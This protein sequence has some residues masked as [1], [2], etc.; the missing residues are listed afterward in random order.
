MNK[1]NFEEDENEFGETRRLD[2]INDEIKKYEHN[3]NLQ[4]KD[5]YLNH[6]QS[7]KFHTTAEN[8]STQGR[9]TENR[10]TSY[11]MRQPS[12]NREPVRKSVPNNRKKG[13][14][15]RGNKNNLLVL[16]I[17]GLLIF[18]CVFLSVF[19]SMGGNNSKKTVFEPDN[20]IQT[21]PKQPK[22][23]TI[24]SDADEKEEEEKEEQ[25]ER[26]ALI[27]E[28]NTSK[29]L[30]VYDITKEKND[31]IKTDKN[32]EVVDEKGDKISLSAIMPGDIVV[33][34]VEEET[35]I[36]TK[37]SFTK[38]TWEK[39]K[40]TKT[41]ID[42]DKKSIEIEGKSYQYTDETIF[43][44]KNKTIDPSRLDEIDV[45]CAKGINDTVWSVDVLEYHGYIVIKNKNKI[46]NGTIEINNKKPVSL[47]SLDKITISEGAHSIVIKGSNIETYTAD[48]FIV[49]DEEF[50]IDLSNTQAKTSVLIVKANVDNYQLY[51]NG[52]LTD[53]TEPVVLNQ[54]D[55]TV[56]VT[57][58]GYLPFEQKI[59]VTEPSVEVNAVLQEEVKKGS[60]SIVTNPTA[61]YIYVNNEYVGVSPVAVTLEYGDHRIYAKMDG[62]MD[63][64]SP[65]TVNKIQETIVVELVEDTSAE[66][67]E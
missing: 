46:E 62:Y 4:D 34:S 56:K 64:S 25:P 27:E 59:S 48:I 44:Y 60:I 26:T 28:I 22:D 1:Y 41:K 19:L 50:S 17:I 31:T 2:S 32:T 40:V 67:Q 15:G 63:V 65:I 29:E 66:G 55:Y 5:A 9:N 39:E 30:I 3:H 52:N 35:G 18:I 14:G 61:A 51:V 21:A 57:K 8:R 13:N 7:E 24:T 33:F 10:N 37:I 47:A 36:A 38:D 53:N 20:E 23:K 11:T 6:F 43:Q 16:I 42:T 58:E 12:Q 49:A 45:I 54:G